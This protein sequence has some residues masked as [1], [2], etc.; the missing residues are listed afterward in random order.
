TEAF[1]EL[2]SRVDDV[3]V[4]GFARIHQDGAGTEGTGSCFH[5]PLK[6]ADNFSFSQAIRRSGSDIICLSERQAALLEKILDVFV[7]EL[8]SPLNVTNWLSSTRHA[9]SG[10]GVE[11]GAGRQACVAGLRKNMLRI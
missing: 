2:H 11:R 8:R 6:P 3:F 1:A 10:S 4:L 9:E 5:P 7:I